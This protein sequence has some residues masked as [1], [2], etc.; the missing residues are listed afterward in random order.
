MFLAYHPSFVAAHAAA[1]ADLQ[2]AGISK[3]PAP[4]FACQGSNTSLFVHYVSGE[5]HMYT[6]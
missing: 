5:Q 3:Q 2:A 1:V 4:V 6:L